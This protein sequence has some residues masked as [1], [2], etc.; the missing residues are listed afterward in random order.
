MTASEKLEPVTDPTYEYKRELVNDVNQLESRKIDLAAD[1]RQEE[2]KL[3]SLT[4]M[5]ANLRERRASIQRE[6]DEIARSLG[7]EGTDNIVL[8]ARIKS[9]RQE[10]EDIDSKIA[11]RSKMLET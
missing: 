8:T 4:T 11:E 2:R 3:K 9:L 1:I 7:E 10:M 6:I 5:I